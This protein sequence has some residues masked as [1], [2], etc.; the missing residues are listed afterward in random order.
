M[1]V[2]LA[3][4]FLLKNEKKEYKRTRNIIVKNKKKNIEIWNAQA[5]LFDFCFY[6]LY[7]F[8]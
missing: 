2:L 7:F 8:E 6:W 5:K 4:P 1:T 3:L